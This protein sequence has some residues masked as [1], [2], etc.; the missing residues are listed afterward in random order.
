MH[1]HSFKVEVSVE[2]DVNP[3]SGW[4]YDHAQI[5]EAMKPLLKLLDHEYLN[6]MYEYGVR[7]MRALLPPAE[8]Q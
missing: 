3:E 5:S 6:D 1:G 8:S 4:V 7:T 2:G